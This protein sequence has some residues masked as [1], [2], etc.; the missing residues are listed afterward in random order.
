MIGSAEIAEMEEAR[1]SSLYSIGTFSWALNQVKNGARVSRLGWNGKGMF[2]F[3]VGGSAFTVNREPL[4]S[5]LGAG[6]EAR[7]Q[8]HIDMRTADGSIVPWLPSQTDMM[9]GDWEEV[10]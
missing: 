8:P 4:L 10:S 1:A 2:I 9:T 5:I 7:Y 6:S 3:L